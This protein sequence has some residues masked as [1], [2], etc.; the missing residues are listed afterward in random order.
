MAYQFGQ[1]NTQAAMLAEL[2]ARHKLA[3]TANNKRGESSALARYRM[4][5][6]INNQMKVMQGLHDQRQEDYGKQICMME[7]Q[8]K[9]MREVYGNYRQTVEHSDTTSVTAEADDSSTAEPERSDD[10]LASGA[11]T[12]TRGFKARLFGNRRKSGGLASA[13]PDSFM[14]KAY[15]SQIDQEIASMKDE[16][17][18]LKVSSKEGGDIDSSARSEDASRRNTVTRTRSG[19]PSW[20]SRFRKKS[21][22]RKK[23]RHQSPS[24]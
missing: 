3:A 12:P 16:M 2:A 17:K 19:S 9:L 22:P 4:R 13:V 20:R 24:R 18:F 23:Q 8:M 10:N 21:P 14:K 5:N 15:I 11:A 7:D 6:A 1:D